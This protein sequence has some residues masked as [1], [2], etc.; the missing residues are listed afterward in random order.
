MSMPALNAIHFYPV[1]SMTGLA[2]AEAAVE[3]WGLAGDRRWMVAAPDG[4]MITQRQRPRLALAA[5]APLPGGGVRLT[6]PG[7]G[8]LDVA[9]PD[10]AEHG[11]MTVELFRDKVEVVRA[12]AAADAWVSAHL[13]TEA[14]L[15]HLDDPARR[16]PIDPRYALPGETV[17]LADGYPLLV[18]T[19]ASLDALNSLIAEGDRAHEGPLPMS[20]FRPN[21]VVDGTAPWAEDGWRRVRI[22]EVTF[23]AVKDCGRCVVTTVDQATAAKGGEPLRT[24]GRHRRIGDK[25]VFGKNLVPENRGVLRVGDPVEVLEAVETQE[26]QEVQ[27]AR[28]ARGVLS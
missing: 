24:L 10:A 26:T 20:R 11:T 12:G 1:K 18:T 3:P 9:V 8:P 21:I 15:V 14:H 13:G 2:P 6:G 16:R 28:E 25:L 4:R 27:E 5:A 7:A 23:R 22:G 19:T 17:S